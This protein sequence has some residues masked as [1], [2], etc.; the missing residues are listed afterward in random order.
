MFD[1]NA[2]FPAR[3]R[4][5]IGL[6]SS[7]CSKVL[8]GSESQLIVWAIYSGGTLRPWIF[9]IPISPFNSSANKVVFTTGDGPGFLLHV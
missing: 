5:V 1:A 2:L 4:V 3:L 6:R 8:F 9:R 7:G